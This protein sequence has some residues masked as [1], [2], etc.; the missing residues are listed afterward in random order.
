MRVCPPPYPHPH[1]YVWF[2]EY[3]QVWDM[4]SIRWPPYHWCISLGYKYHW[5][6]N[7]WN[8]ETHWSDVICSKVEIR[9]RWETKPCLVIE[10][11]NVIC[12]SP[13][14]IIRTTASH[15]GLYCIN[16]TRSGHLTS[17]GAWSEIIIHMHCTNKNGVKYFVGQLIKFIIYAVCSPNVM[18]S[19]FFVITF[20]CFG[21]QMK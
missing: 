8:R 7:D 1:S 6:K 18:K 2:T 4:W 5:L 10:L 14:M 12:L 15:A 11:Y 13:H 17:K 20:Q 9:H 21:S 19:L 3:L 16:I